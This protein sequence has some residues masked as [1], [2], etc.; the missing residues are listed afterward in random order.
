MSA[1]TV[2]STDSPCP[3]AWSFV[4]EKSRII[5]AA[6]RRTWTD[7]RV[8]VE[9]FHHELVV[10]IA[11]NFHKFDPERASATT[12]VYLRA[13][14]VRDHMLRAL[15]ARKDRAHGTASIEAQGSEGQA[16]QLAAGAGDYGSPE[17]VVAQVTLAEV[18]R[19][20]S[21]LQADAIRSHLESWTGEEVRSAFR[22]SMS[23]RNDRLRR[24]ARRLEEPDDP[25]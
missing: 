9:D 8:D 21:P 22:C 6:A 17:A 18:L 7:L 3:A 20:A 2:P 5:H 4:L 25:R 16:M 12:W 11:R 15:S 13:R 19:M 24:L 14:Y 23:A 10:D 1:V